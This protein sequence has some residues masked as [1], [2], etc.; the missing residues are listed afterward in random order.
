MDEVYAAQ[1]VDSTEDDTDMEQE[2]HEIKEEFLGNMNRGG[3]CYPTD[4]VYILALH[5]WAL[6]RGIT[7]EEV[8][9]MLLMNS[10][11]PRSAFVYAVGERLQLYPD[12]EDIQSKESQE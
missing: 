12:S 5:S 6:F 4:L 10:T 11:C 7:Q 9:R 1:R 8:T 3:L 2:I